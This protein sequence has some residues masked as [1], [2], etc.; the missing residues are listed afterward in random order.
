MICF[1]L[2]CLMGTCPRLGWGIRLEMMSWALVV[3]GREVLVVRVAVAARV[4]VV[5]VRVRVELGLKDTIRRLRATLSRGP[6]RGCIII[7]I[8]IIITTISTSTST[9]TTTI[10]IITI[11]NTTT[12]R[13]RSPSPVY[14]EPPLAAACLETTLLLLQLQQLMELALLRPRLL[15]WGWRVYRRTR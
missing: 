10:I 9:T 1:R 11:N 8:I 5:Q 6:A 2:I 15:G 14:T 4:R 7:I 12:S 13:Q 3:V